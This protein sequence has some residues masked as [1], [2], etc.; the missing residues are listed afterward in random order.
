[1]LVEI[2]KLHVP[3]QDNLPDAPT[4]LPSSIGALDLVNGG[5]DYEPAARDRDEDSRPVAAATESKPQPETGGNDSGPGYDL[6]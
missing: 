5:D 3:D 4:N 2:K 1:M 6:C